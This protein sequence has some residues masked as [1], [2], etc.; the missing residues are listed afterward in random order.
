MHTEKGGTYFV[1]VY[2]G[3]KRSYPCEVKSI[4]QSDEETAYLFFCGGTHWSTVFLFD[5]KDRK[6]ESGFYGDDSD[7][8][9]LFLSRHVREGRHAV[10]SADAA[11]YRSKIHPAKGTAV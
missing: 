2:L 1:G 6:Y 11:L 4:L 10:R 8:A 9:A 7:H 3:T 5:Q